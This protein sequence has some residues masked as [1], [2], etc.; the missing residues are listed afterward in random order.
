MKHLCLKPIKRRSKSASRFFI[1]ALMGLAVC[2][3]SATETKADPL[4]FSNVVALQGN[5]RV[6]LFT[7]PGTIVFGPQ[8]SF[9]VDVTGTIPPGSPV[10]TLMITFAE[11]GQAAI[12]QTFSIPAF[13]VIPPPFTQ[14]FTVSTLGANAQG[15]PV[16]LTVDILGS[17]T[18]FII[19]GGARSGQLVD[20][21]TYTFY[22]A[23]PVPEPATFALFCT[24]V[25]AC[26]ARFR[27]QRSP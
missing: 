4:M 15:V 23:E 18:D 10:Q 3:F 12:V 21:F 7:N 14:L 17:S 13:G 6:D 24:G 1:L 11:A 2:L 9:L 5:V 22:V 27:R 20:S 16:T 8:V 26:V 25:A 19:P